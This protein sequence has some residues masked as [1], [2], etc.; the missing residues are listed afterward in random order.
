MFFEI[1][2]DQL[3][4]VRRLAGLVPFGHRIAALIDFALE[5]LGLFPRSKIAS[6]LGSPA[7]DLATTRALAALI[8]SIADT[9][10]TMAFSALV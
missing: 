2:V 10:V 5:A 1:A 4:H 3:P 6:K 8:N 7:L 9:L